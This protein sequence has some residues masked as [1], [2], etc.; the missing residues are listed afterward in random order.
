MLLFLEILRK[1]HDPLSLLLFVFLTV[2]FLTILQ[3]IGVN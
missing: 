1:H 3:E 2:G